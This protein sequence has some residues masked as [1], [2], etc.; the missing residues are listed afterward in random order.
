MCRRDTPRLGALVLF[1]LFKRFV[2]CR[3]S[4]LR[5]IQLATAPSRTGSSLMTRRR[6]PLSDLLRQLGKPASSGVSVSYGPET[7]VPEHRMARMMWTCDPL[8]TV[9]A[10]PCVR[11]SNCAG[12]NLLPYSTIEFDPYNFPEETWII[13]PCERHSPVFSSYP[14]A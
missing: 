9:E 12:A 6:V 13:V 2:R 5:R 14:E 8:A 11:P 4:G 1:G 3:A 7:I 10:D